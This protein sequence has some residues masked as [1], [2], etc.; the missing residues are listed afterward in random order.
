MGAHIACNSE[1]YHI[2]DTPSIKVWRRAVW[3]VLAKHSHTLGNKSLV[4]VLSLGNEASRA[5]TCISL[6][7]F[8]EPACS[9]WWGCVW[10]WHKEWNI[11]A[12]RNLCTEI[13][14]LGIACEGVL[15]SMLIGWLTIHTGF[16]IVC[17]TLHSH[18]VCYTPHS[19]TV[20]YTPHS[21]T[22]C[23]IPHSHTVCYT[24]HSHTV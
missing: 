4:L 19:H 14:L 13:L 15:F 12:P 23:Y 24:P 6:L 22:V 11:W 18:T 9:F 17:Y 20:C 7:F 3:G 16:L 21:H 1:L 5:L 10:M 8:R 2:C